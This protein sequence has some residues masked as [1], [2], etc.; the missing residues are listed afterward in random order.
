A[1]VVA[2]RDQPLEELPRAIDF[3]HL[4]EALDE[5]EGADRESRLVSCK[6]VDAVR[7]VAVDEPVRGE[8]LGD[9]IGSRLGA[10]VAVLDEA[11][12]RDHQ[13]R[14]V[15]L[16]AVAKRLEK[17]VRLRVDALALDLCA[18]LAARLPP[19]LEIA[20]ATVSLRDLQQPVERDPGHHL[21]IHEVSRLAAD[22][23]DALVGLLPLVEHGAAGTT[24]EIPEDV[25][26]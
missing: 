13:V 11:D 14:R 10:R 19:A 4:C 22:L 9:S 2:E 21:R 18:N 23:P 7:E 5:P 3:A 15:Q 26:D 1:H 16:A 6:P 25:V 8:L 12:D 17:C 20:L 24:Q